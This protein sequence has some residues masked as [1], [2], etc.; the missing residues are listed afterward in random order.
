M[1]PSDPLAAL[2][3]RSRLYT[4]PTARTTKIIKDPKTGEDITKKVI[5]D[6]ETFFERYQ[7]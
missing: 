2:A 7:R 4:D 5:E 3:I 6:S 1:D